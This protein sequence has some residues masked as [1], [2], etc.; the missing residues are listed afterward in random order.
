[1]IKENGTKPAK[2]GLGFRL[3]SKYLR[4]FHN[5]IYYRKVY[6]LNTENIPEDNPLMIVSDHQ[7]CL[8]DA[9]AL[10]MAIYPT[11][12]KRQHRILTRASVFK[13][14]F[15]KALRWIGAL[16]AFRMEYDGVETLANNAGTF[17]EA[18]EELLQNGTLIIYPEAG[19]Q[20]KRW[21][22]TFSYGYTRLLFNAAEKSN[23]EKDFFILPSCNHYSGY[24]DMQEDVLIKF[25]TP[26]SIAPFYELYKTKPRTAQR[27]VNALVREQ[28]SGMML[29]ITDLDNYE[30]IDYLRETYGIKYAETKGYNSDILPEKLLADQ[31]LFIALETLKGEQPEQIQTLYEDIRRLKKETEQFRIKDYCFENPPK[32]F[33]LFVK[34]LLL[35][36]LLPVFLVSCVPNLFIFLSPRILTRKLNDIMFYSSINFGF[37]ILISIPVFYSLTFALIWI[38]ANSVLIAL[39]YLICIPFLGIFAWYYRKHLL[40]LLGEW[41]FNSLFNKGKLK[42]LIMLRKQIFQ[43]LDRLLK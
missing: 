7:N 2:P 14:A 12:R 29:N 21:L 5:K 18:E 22:G 38:F 35:L 33:S 13:P 34:G 10:L 42:D 26:I 40:N 43:S 41:R 39:A 25:G 30:P 11:R 24:L 31:Q 20:D 37:Y 28:I 1:M 9:L 15:Q 6:W 32:A 23:F 8:S 27:Q 36:L 17:N 16:P 4:F 3:F 19:H